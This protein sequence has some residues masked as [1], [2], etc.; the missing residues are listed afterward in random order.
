MEDL[1]QD[2]GSERSQRVTGRSRWTPK[3]EQILIL[4]S[5]FNSGTVNPSKDDTVRIRKLL[6]KFGTVAD[7]NIFY[8]FQNRRS[9]SRRRQRQLQQL[10]AEALHQDNDHQLQP[11]QVGGAGAGASASASPSPSPSYHHHQS[12]PASDPAVLAAYN[13]GC[14]SSYLASQEP[15]DHALFFPADHMGF[16]EIDHNS[17]LNFH[18]VSGSINVFINGVATEVERGPIDMKSKFGEDVMLVHSSGVP[19]PTNDFGFLLH[20]LQPGESYFLV[21]KAA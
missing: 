18:S 16:P 6:E 14:S 17:D 3:P 1:G 20:D 5:I 19:V 2:Y 8:W 15:M 9:R 21:L 7:A 13:G 10:A 12:N 4:E 11:H